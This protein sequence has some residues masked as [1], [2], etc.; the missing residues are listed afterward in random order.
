MELVAYAA[1]VVDAARPM[2]DQRIAN[3]AAMCVLLVSFVRRVPG[4]GPAPWVVRLRPWAADVADPAFDFLER[5]GDAVEIFERVDHAKRAA[6]LA[7]AVVG[8]QQDERVVQLTD[9]GEDGDQPSDLLVSMIEERCKCF[10]QLES[11]PL[12]RVRQRV[13]RL[14]TGIAWRELCL[15]RD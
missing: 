10:L 5:F 2:R 3:A 1:G 9:I 7:G 15:R 6:F 11:K 4:L 8:H 14:D 13:P 12:L